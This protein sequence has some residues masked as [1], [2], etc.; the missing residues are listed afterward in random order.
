MISSDHETI[1]YPSTDAS[2]VPDIS[3]D[4]RNAAYA[5]CTGAYQSLGT[6]PHT[7]EYVH[8][9]LPLALSSM[10]GEPEH[11]DYF[12]P[13]KYSITYK[14]TWKRR[15]STPI[16]TVKT[17]T[18][19]AVRTVA[20][21]ARPNHHSVLYVPESYSNSYSASY[22]TTVS[23][24]G[25]VS[26]NSSSLSLQNPRYRPYPNYANPNPN[27]NPP[28]PSRAPQNPTMH[29]PTSLNF[30]SITRPRLITS[31]SF[32]ISPAKPRIPN[33]T[34]RTPDPTPSRRS[35]VSEDPD[36][37]I[38]LLL[39]QVFFLLQSLVP[40]QALQLRQDHLPGLISHFTLLLS[41]TA[42]PTAKQLS[43]AL[44]GLY[45]LWEAVMPVLVRTPKVN[46]ELDRLMRKLGVLRT[47]LRE[48][49]YWSWECYYCLDFAEA[50]GVEGVRRDMLGC[51][52][53]WEVGVLRGRM[54]GGWCW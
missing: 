15:N 18:T 21:E 10:N 36:P 27:L 9:Y 34:A 7:C 26:S 42:E 23:P 20:R 37:P 47:V 2:L 13:S 5:I 16:E 32:T 35:S 31:Q 45:D 14:R 51:L 28:A 53:G 49:S 8:I 54:P 24:V 48:R 4:I 39:S 29:L 33:I 30:P 40:P 22:S 12:L 44:F 6:K 38:P 52:D 17:K 25:P 50:G 11:M 43:D 3:T 46:A 19:G 41:P 1:L